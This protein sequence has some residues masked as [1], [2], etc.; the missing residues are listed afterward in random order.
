M[1]FEAIYFHNLHFIFTLSKH[2]NL[3]FYVDSDLL[4]F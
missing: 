4:N 3:K 1:E 2:N